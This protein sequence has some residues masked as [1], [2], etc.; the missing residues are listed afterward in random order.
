MALI[1]TVGRIGAIFVALG[2]II[3]ILFWLRPRRGEL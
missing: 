1:E 3:F 2:W